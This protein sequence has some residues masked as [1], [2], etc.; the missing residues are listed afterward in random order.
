MEETMHN[1]FDV[2]S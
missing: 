2:S 1:V